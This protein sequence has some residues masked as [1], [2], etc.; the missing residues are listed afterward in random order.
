MGG[1]ETYVRELVPA[2][3]DVRPDL[4]LVLYTGP[5]G[6]A[7]LD[8]EPWATSV[9]LVTHPL[10]G[11]PGTRALTE[12]SL[13]GWIASGDRLD[14]L[15]NVALTAP[16]WTRPPNVVL[17]P[18]VT[19]LRQ[20]ETVGRA[21]SL[22]WRSLVLPAAR[23]ADR[24]ITLSEAARREI[25]EDIGVPSE[26]IDVVPLGY[27]LAQRA[28]PTPGEELRKRL[29][30]LAGPVLLAVSALTPHKNVAAL[31]NAVAKVRTALPEVNLV[32]P[33]N[34]SA[35]G[36]ELKRVAV[37]LG[38]ER[39]VCF[40]GWVSAEDLE[41]L[42]DLAAVFAFPSLRE[43]FGLPLLEAMARGVPVVAAAS[44]ALPEVA[45]DAALYFDP[46]SPE[47]LATAILRLLRDSELHEQLV[48]RGKE[49]QKLFTW[50]RT[51]VETLESFERAI[52]ARK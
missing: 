45:G 12:A 30:L 29:E 27:G 36:E 40:P 21:R 37:E 20:P 46:H 14:V 8:A 32:V 47:E 26:R 13:L 17:L 2:L 38:I 18:D 10:L 22:L 19:W 23:R 44:S 5:R 28:T 51:A 33:G 9:T 43:G 15:H 42:Y 4:E 50:R 6:R 7:L 35:H 41:A 39:H 34:P 49:R 1:L 52:A 31:L 3:L 24:I 48:A 16:L 25:V 11:R